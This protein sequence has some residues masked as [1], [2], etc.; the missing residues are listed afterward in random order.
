M[1]A[2]PSLSEQIAALESVVVSQR[3]WIAQAEIAEARGKL[4]MD[5]AHTRRS[6]PVL[7]AALE[8]LRWL[9]RNQAA[10][11]AAAREKSA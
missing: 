5:L 2:R 11:R 1:S 6:Q 4:R 7:E 3:G 10:V 9:D 8:T